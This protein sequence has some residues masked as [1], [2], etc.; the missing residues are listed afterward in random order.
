[1]E[2]LLHARTK[3]LETT[4]GYGDGPS[5]RLFGQ[6][7][8]PFR[9]IILWSWAVEWRGFWWDSVVEV[10]LEEGLRRLWVPF[11]ECEFYLV[12]D[13]LLPYY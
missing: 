2:L 5:I 4:D 11:C 8:F 12:D 13:G 9:L 6:R 10:G 3:L 7:L 1:M